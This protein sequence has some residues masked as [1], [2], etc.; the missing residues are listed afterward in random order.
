MSLEGRVAVVTGGA[1]GIGRAICRR[2]HENGARVAILDL[3]GEGAREVADSLASGGECLALPCDLSKPEEIE[4][5][6]SRCLEALGRIDILVNNAAS[7]GDLRPVSE[8]SYENWNAVLH[9]NL[10]G[11][12]LLTQAAIS[13]MISRGAGGRIVNITAIQ[14]SNPLPGYAPYAASKGGLASFT[15]SL[16]VEL[17]GTGILAN[18]VEVGSVTTEGVYET[19][20]ERYAGLSQEEF[21][22]VLDENSATLA[23]RQ[24]RPEDIAAV[25]NFLVSDENR[26]VVG[27]I[28]R[29]DGGRIL[30]RKSDPLF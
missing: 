18:A 12:F 19:R 1:K 23:G 13:D 25:V 22:Q 7:L 27:E 28:L 30:S 2:L 29:A 3:D 14:S 8:D 5:A 24:G 4:R 16:A 9:A 15:R 20:L 26:F 10:I 17:A 6:A 11:P 21:L